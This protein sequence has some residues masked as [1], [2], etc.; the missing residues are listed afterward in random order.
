MQRA[1]GGD[2]EKQDA[3]GQVN[4]LTGSSPRELGFIPWAMGKPQNSGWRGAAELAPGAKCLSCFI[5][6]KP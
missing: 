2:L 6:F 4:S 3:A 5:S 1:C